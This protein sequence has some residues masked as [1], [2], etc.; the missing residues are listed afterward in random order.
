MCRVS[1]PTVSAVLCQQRGWGAGSTCNVN[2]HNLLAMS[3]PEA[4]QSTKFGVLSCFCDTD[5]SQLAALHYAR[6][7]PCY[8]PTGCR[9]GSSSKSSGQLFYSRC[10]QSRNTRQKKC[11]RHGRAHCLPLRHRS[12]PLLK[13]DLLL[14]WPTRRATQKPAVTYA[15]AYV[16]AHCWLL[17]PLHAARTER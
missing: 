1:S 10:G 13:L 12:R 9:S 16:H 7:T 2:I 14:P 5:L 3:S 8:G 6:C 15:S 11:G 17:Q 4:N